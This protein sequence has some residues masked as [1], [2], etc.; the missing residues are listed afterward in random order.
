M[1]TCQLGERGQWVEMGQ[2]FLPPACANSYVGQ[3]GQLWALAYNIHVQDIT[4]C[5]R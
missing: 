2:W 4:D 5:F 3:N 1:K